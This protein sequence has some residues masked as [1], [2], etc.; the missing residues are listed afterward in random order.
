[1]KLDDHGGPFQPRPFYDSM[2]SLSKLKDT[3]QSEH[4]LT[5]SVWLSVV[6]HQLASSD[7]AQPDTSGRLK[8]QQQ[9]SGCHVP[10]A[11]RLVQSSVIRIWA[12]QFCAGERQLM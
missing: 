6:K 11:G 2:I 10:A 12:P 4:M 1:L 7:G 9:P 5:C 8:L 3:E